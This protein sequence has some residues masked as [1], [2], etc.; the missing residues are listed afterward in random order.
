MKTMENDF[1]DYFSPHRQ[2]EFISQHDIAFL[3]ILNTNTYQDSDGFYTMPLPMTEDREKLTNNH[4]LAYKRFQTLVNKV[5]RNHAYKQEFTK[6]IEGTISR[7]EAEKLPNDALK[8]GEVECW[9]LP[10]H[11]V[12][13]KKRKSYE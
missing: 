11:G 9:Y 10:H 1:S 13:R 8:T 2:H 12:Y 6:L 5:E 7:G 3:R 4:E